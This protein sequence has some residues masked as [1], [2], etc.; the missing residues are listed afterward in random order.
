MILL[1]EIDVDPQHRVP[2][3]DAVDRLAGSM[4][5]IGLRTPITIRYFPDRP[6]ADGSGSE[7]S[8]VLV[9]GAHRLKAAKQLGWK[10][11]ECF[12]ATKDDND[13]DAALWEIDENL[14][15]AEL[16]AAEHA[17]LTKR[18]AEII[19]ARAAAVSSQPATKL[20]KR[21]RKGEGRP[22]KA[23]SVRDQAAKTGQSKDKVARSRKR[24][25]RLGKETLGRVVGTSLAKG[26][27]LDALAKLAAGEREVLVSRAEAGEK[28]TARQRRPRRSAIEIATDE[29]DMSVEAVATAC[30]ATD[31]VK[32]PHVPPELAER[33]IKRIGEGMGVLRR[34]KAR[35]QEAQQPGSVG[36]ELQVEPCPAT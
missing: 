18:R 34:F 2:T 36:K 15:R 11:I 1:S 26:T 29:L 28:V 31:C 17:L 8:Y 14:M 35:I 13:L 25:E 4:N 7:D 24:A 9:A 3:K 32:I 22:S 33:L 16:D 19:E 30:E 23:A 21:G 6:S 10:Q 27:E 5:A 20:S 12:V